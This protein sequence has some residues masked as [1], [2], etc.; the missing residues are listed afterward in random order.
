MYPREGDS[1]IDLK[2]YLQSLDVLVCGQ[3]CHVEHLLQDFM[4]HKSQTCHPSQKSDTTPISLFIDALSQSGQSKKDSIVSDTESLWESLGTQSRAAWIE[5]AESLRR[6]NAIKKV[7]ENSVGHKNSELSANSQVGETHFNDSAIFGQNITSES[8]KENLVGAK[9]LEP[10]ISNSSKRFR[11]FRG[12]G[13]KFTAIKP[14]TENPPKKAKMEPNF[15]SREKRRSLI[16]AID[17]VK[18][19][20][21]DKTDLKSISAIQVHEAASK[22][23]RKLP[24]KDVVEEILLG[25]QGPSTLVE[26]T[27]FSYKNQKQKTHEKVKGFQPVGRRP[28]SGL[29]IAPV[30]TNKTHTSKESG[31][32]EDQSLAGNSGLNESRLR[33]EE[34]QLHL[35]SAVGCENEFLTLNSTNEHRQLISTETK[36]NLTNDF[37][38]M[39]IT[40]QES[41]LLEE[42]SIQRETQVLLVLPSGQMILTDLTEDHLANHTD[43]TH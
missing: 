42:A 40:M 12:P 20:A 18:N 16:A 34:T 23:R 39:Q 37:E 41:N 7:S 31:P 38:P 32:K 43:E 22:K 10:V 27:R 8:P 4:S 14:K 11:G 15:P 36:L 33:S 5:A 1:K 19:W 35:P 29:S 25:G 9:N 28:K 17:R 24:G 13:G 26:A 30:E 6:L 21:N 2:Y 3:C